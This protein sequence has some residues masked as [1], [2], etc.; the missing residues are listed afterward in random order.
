MSAVHLA[1]VIGSCA[2]A[3]AAAGL[4]YLLRRPDPL[5]KLGTVRVPPGHPEQWSPVLDDLDGD[6]ADLHNLTWPNAEWAS[7]VN[8]AHLNLWPYD[9]FEDAERA[10]DRSRR[11]TTTAC[12]CGAWH[13]RYR[14]RRA[15]RPDRVGGA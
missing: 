9:T 7:I 14:A 5:D 6:L 3:A 8:C 1:A 15:G 13:I 10:V 2:L 4:G 12:R 11:S